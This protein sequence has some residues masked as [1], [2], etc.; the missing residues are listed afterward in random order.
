MKNLLL[1]IMILLFSSCGGG[2]GSSDTSSL[3]TVI[4]R[5]D[6][7]PSDNNI[8]FNDDEYSSEQWQRGNS[9]LNLISLNET[10]FGYNSGNPIIVQVVDNGI[11]AD[12]EDLYYNMSFSSSYNAND[13]TND[14]TPLNLYD[15]QHGTAVAGII[16]AVG[17]NNIG[18]KGVAPSAKLAGFALEIDNGYFIIGLDTLEKAWLSGDN[19]NNIAISNNSWGSCVS[20]DI[21]EEELLEKGS[22][23]LRDEKG[24]IYLFAGGNGRE[25]DPSI[26]SD[27][28]NP[29]NMATS[30]TSYLNNSQ[31]SIAVAAVGSDNEFAYY[32]SPGANILVSGYSGDND[33]NR[34]IA[35]TLPEGTGNS[36]Y[37]FFEDSELNYTDSFSGTSASSPMVAGAL[38]L[39]LEACPTLSYRDVKYLI[40]KNSRKVGLGYITNS[41]GLSH[42]NDYGFGL[43]NPTAIIAE[44]TSS[45]SLLGEKRTITASNL[46]SV[47]NSISTTPLIKNL[48]ISEDIT[49]E[50]VGLT[51]TSNYNSPESLQI[52]LI[53]PNGT[54]SELIHFNNQTG[55][56]VSTYFSSGFRL[57]SQAFMGETSMSSA[58]GVWQ[59][60]VTS[61]NSSAS[62]NLNALSLEIVGH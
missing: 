53:S 1:Y 30:N 14:P 61:N 26:N 38:A 27:C 21:D 62:G 42:S 40:A 51:V 59:V 2:G 48:T 13:Q 47:S 36:L 11:E 46:Y 54:E 19:A 24:R 18:L 58:N 8:V 4:I 37:T 20:K 32:S 43:I 44:C 39:V 60:K 33:S 17:Y 56:N 31:Y 41:A 5:I 22:R 55:S 3:S 52:K 57:S 28:P 34:G 49:I 16:A 15:N 9:F 25:G 7:T 12:H 10:Y 23:I 50:W 35:T 29:N 45:Y 6:P